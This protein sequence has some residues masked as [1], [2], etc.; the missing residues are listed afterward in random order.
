MQGTRLSPPPGRIVAILRGHAPEAVA[1]IVDGLVAGGITTVEVTL[2]SPGA[3]DSI[4]ALAARDDL[5]AGA[6]TVLSVAAAEAA[7][8]A[9]ATFLVAPHLDPAVIRAAAARGVAM[10]P[11]ALTPTEIFTAWQAGA[12]AVKVFPAGGL[13]AGYIAAVRGP[14]AGIPLVPTGGI[15]DT[16]AAAFL[17]AGALAVGVGGWLTGDA[18]PETVQLRAGRLIAAVGG[19]A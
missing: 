2:D 1:G 3:H 5:V 7:I 13:G 8:D 19:A 15:D 16:N 17:A 10:L 4:A 9:G 14:L 6:G 11:G 18:D 12:A